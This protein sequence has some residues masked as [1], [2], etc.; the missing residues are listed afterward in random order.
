MIRLINRVTGTEMWVADNRIAEYLARGHKVAPAPGGK[1]D[2]ATPAEMAAVRKKT[3][4]K[5]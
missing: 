3:T 4:R 5:K 1:P 2:K